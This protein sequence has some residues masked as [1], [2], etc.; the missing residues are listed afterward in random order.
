MTA[1]AQQTIKS[2]IEETI[3]YIN[4]MKQQPIADNKYLAVFTDIMLG[5]QQIDREV[6]FGDEP[7]SY[8]MAWSLSKSVINGHGKHPIIMSHEEYVTKSIEMQEKHLE[9]LTNLESTNN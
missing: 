2:A 5:V 6:F 1:T 3:G 8:D 7:Y 9:T 4:K